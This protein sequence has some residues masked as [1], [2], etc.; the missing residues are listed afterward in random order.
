[1]TWK[2]EFT[3]QAARQFNKLVK[4]YSK[5][6]APSLLL[7]WLNW[8]IQGNWENDYKVRCPNSGHTESAITVY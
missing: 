7:A 8:M 6:S 2:I 3:V 1:M 4:R 5:E